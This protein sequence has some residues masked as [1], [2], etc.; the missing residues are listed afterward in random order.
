MLD[1]PGPEGA[2]GLVVRCA[3]DPGSDD[4]GGRTVVDHVRLFPIR[5]DVRWTYR[6]HEQILPALRRAGIGVRWTDLIVRHTGYADV[7]LRARKL[8]RDRRILVGELEERPDDPFLLFNRGA[9]ALEQK[10]WRAAP[11]YL[12]RSLARS[13]PG[14]SITR[15]LYAMIA[16]APDARR[17]R[18][19][20]AHLRRGPL[21]RARR[22]RA[23]VPQGVVHRQTGE[24]AEAERRWRRIP[25]LGPPERFASVDMGIYGHLT[26][27]NL[28]AMA[29]D[30]G[31][32]EEAARLWGEV[33][34]EGPGDREALAK[35]RA[36]ALAGSIG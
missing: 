31:G 10:G 12:E 28:A 8:D 32:I 35:L 18:G 26:R 36:P 23:A 24:P 25:G 22:R 17:P 9:I 7:G 1:G 33:L 5:A 19:R 3:C 30:R 21:R 34:A 4:S 29:A 27:R 14:D 2:A 6:V 13:S 15:K 11:G 20:A 16:V